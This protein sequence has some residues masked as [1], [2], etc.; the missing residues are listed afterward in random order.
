[1][2]RG[3]RAA[4]LES[5]SQIARA[6]PDVEIAARH[7]P[8]GRAL[9]YT[10]AVSNLV[11][12]AY[13]LG[14]PACAEALARD[15]IARAPLHATPARGGPRP[16]LDEMRRFGP[17][18]SGIAVLIERCTPAA[19][20]FVADDVLDR[21]LWQ[22]SDAALLD[23]LLRAHASESTGAASVDSSLAVD[24]TSIGE[25]HLP[26][27]ACALLPD[28]C[29]ADAVELLL[30]ARLFSAL[31]TLDDLVADGGVDEI[32]LAGYVAARVDVVRDAAAVAARIG[33]AADVD[34]RDAD[35]DDVLRHARAH[36]VRAEAGVR[37]R[38]YPVPLEALD[39]VVAKR[40]SWRYAHCVRVAVALAATS[41]LGAE[42]LD[43]FIE[44]FGNEA[45]FWSLLFGAV[46]ANTPQYEA[47]RRRVCAEI[48][49]APYDAVLWSA[50]VD[51]LGA[52]PAVAELE[53]RRR[54]HGRVTS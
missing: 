23:A 35:G 43:Q 1:M 12:L 2:N 27:L 22:P 32:E 17:H 40:P 7:S 4:R 10:R 9:I 14:L 18:S 52:P 34:Y 20:I 48:L 6:Q 54:T 44:R 28:G 21:V 11:T 8:S 26:R 16:W 53:R 24:S 38:Q 46:D 15:N 41:G 47:L 51:T 25:A 19:R 39:F 50:L 33:E 5:N 13:A 37:T 36:V 31:P 3:H 49:A 30:D 45:S 42:L 29:V